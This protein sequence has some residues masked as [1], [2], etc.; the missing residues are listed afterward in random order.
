MFVT[1][2]QP[3][4]SS[5][6]PGKRQL[7]TQAGADFTAGR[8][9]IEYAGESSVVVEVAADPVSEVVTEVEAA[10]AARAR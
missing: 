7:K 10:D 9:V 6:P 2:S 5:S 8:A 1:L 4:G 3:L